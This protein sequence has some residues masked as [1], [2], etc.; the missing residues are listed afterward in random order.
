M[1]STISRLGECTL[2]ADFRGIV[3]GDEGFDELSD[4][5]GD[6]LPPFLLS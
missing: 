2:G 6:A 3:L 4:N 5:V 1:P